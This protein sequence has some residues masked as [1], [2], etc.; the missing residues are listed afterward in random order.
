MNLLGDGLSAGYVFDP[1]TT[2][3]VGAVRWDQTRDRQFKIMNT[4]ESPVRITALSIAPQ[5]TTVTGE[6]TIIGFTAQTL[7]PNTEMLVTVR[8]DPNNR[9]GALVGNLNVSSD[10]GAI[11]TRPPLALTANSTTPAITSDPANMMY[12]FGPVDV[13]RAGGMTKTFKL[14]NSGTAILD[15]TSVA[16]AGTGSPF[17]VTAV[18]PAQVN[19]GSDFTLT[20]TYDPAAVQTQTGTLN[21]GVA[22]VFMGSMT[23]SFAL[24][25]RGIDRKFAFT[26]PGLFPETYRNPGGKAP[27]RDVVV[28]NTGE[29]PLTI[30]AAMVTGEPIWSLVDPQPIVIPGGGSAAFKVKFS[31]IT[32]GKAPTGTLVLSHD[33]DTGNNRGV[34]TLDGFGKT[35]IL[36]IAP[37]AVISLGTTAVGFPVRLSDSFLDKITVTNGDVTTFKVNKLVLRDINGDSP[38]QL[39]DELT[40][41]ML[42]PG[43]SRN[44]DI[45][46][47][48][49]RVGEFAA[50]LEIYLDEDTEPA[51]VVQ[52]TGTAVEVEV[53]G[54]GGCAA[55]TPGGAGGLGWLL[56]LATSGL[57]VTLRRRKQARA[58]AI[59]VSALA[60]VLTAT[61]SQAQSTSRN[62][63]LS[64]FRAAPSTT[65][66]LLQVE[67]PFV[68]AAG[69][70][71]LGL[72][73]S[74][75]TNPLQVTT[76]MGD[77]FNLVSSRTTFDL[78]LVFAFANR[79][80][81]G[82]R[83]ATMNQNGDAN[84][85]VQGLEPGVGTA[86]GDA[87]LHGKVSLLRG[88]ALAANLTLPTATDDAFAGPGKVSGS[89]LLLL[90]SG[91]KRFS[92]TANLGFGY[93]TKIVLGNI[94]Q[95]NR[96]LVGAGATLRTTD[97][98]WLSAEV[99]GAVAI[100]Q[101]ERD[102]AS[103]LEGMVSLRYRAARAVGISAGLGTGLMRGIGAPQLHGVI[104]FELSP[105]ARALEPIRPP[106]PYVAP[107][108]RD[109]DGIPDADDRCAD[110]A[111]DLDGFGD[112]D[113]CPDL[114]N[115]FDG[116][117]DA[118][119]K[120]PLVREDKDGVAD[121]DGCPDNDDDGDNIPV[122]KDKCPGDAEDFD[123]FEDSDGCPELDNDQDG[124]LDAAD[125]CPIQPETINGTT[126]D[127]GCPDAGESMILLG[128]DRIDLVQQMTFVGQTNK[129]TPVT[130]GILAQVAATLRANPEIARLRIGVHV[131]RR[132][133][134]DQA[135]TEKRAEALRDWLVQWGVEP[136]RLD[137]RGFGSTKL[138]V[139]AQRKDAA[140][141]N[142]R[143]ELTIMERSR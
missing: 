119:D 1:L 33:D 89:G 46:F 11:I 96:A 106:R 81:V 50:Q 45:V 88:V 51:T 97:A 136:H 57:A 27:V 16:I 85:D 79:L 15:I 61:S 120:C 75:T 100:G 59:A 86:L 5:G 7:A 139:K 41:E 19:P 90:G 31:P 99:F 23:T 143:V 36:S 78:G 137:V 93:Q 70:W 26:D 83:M 98:M 44:F 94:T 28:R 56:M 126:D 69:D 13:D 131:N 124:I 111:E 114:D 118:T 76:S 34:I 12:D 142:D 130:L 65:G 18:T 112:A 103:P 49:A 20:V 123:G 29:A 73:I 134:G 135:L 74:H 35:P 117:P 47:S 48:A 108:D 55:T 133:K 68:G 25:G 63:D 38:F 52:L 72:S 125:R 58:M 67:S 14:T 82:A 8:A 53:T 9:L 87:L 102:A 101:R 80:E 107:P 40:G 24:S 115:D 43:E 132:G 2:F 64:T 10:L 4:S 92:A 21:V 66:D 42:A 105:N 128:A 77:E 109:R 84:G 129:L 62:L 22:G 39:E 54:G 6:L 121:D 37:A 17:S 3:D 140:A 104:A 141:V 110:E 138:I 95:G 113:G 122:P 71:E 127:D 32:G 91:G 60:L 30:S 116:L